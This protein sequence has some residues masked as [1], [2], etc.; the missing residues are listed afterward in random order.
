MSRVNELAY[1]AYEVSDLD[2]WEDFAV[3]LLGMQIGEKGDKSLTLRNDQKAHRWI[4]TDGPAN[5]LTI[6]GYG[7]ASSTDLD[8]IA[9][10]LAE[11]GYD[12]IEGDAALAAERKVDRIVVTTD[13]MG[14]RI[15]LVTGFKNAATPFHS[16]LILDSFTTGVQGAG[17]HFVTAQG[18][19]RDIYMNFYENLL[20][21]R[22]SDRIVGPSALGFSADAMFLH[23]NP[24]HH[25]IALADI[26]VPLKTHHFML[27]VRDRRDLGAAW[28][29]VLKSGQRLEMTIGSHPNDLMFSF[30]VKTPSGFAV[31]YGW[32]GLTIDDDATWKVQLYDRL[33]SWGHWDPDQELAYLE[34]SKAKAGL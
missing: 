2:E 6:S 18:V 22:I 10:K 21:F 16:D 34:E 29:R 17:H 14:N 15:E 28:D 33:D 7:V 23:C 32:G 11:A 5:D 20:G 30:Y 26:P 24:R 27:Q 1:V 8:A 31:E 19:D 3:N 12:A 13:P 25:T 4:L 9:K